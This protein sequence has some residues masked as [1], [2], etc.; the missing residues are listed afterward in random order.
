VN[1][2]FS[3]LRF[4]KVLVVSLTMLFFLPAQAKRV[5]LVMGNDNCTSA[6]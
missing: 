6:N 4:I 2:D 5:A 1:L 3:A